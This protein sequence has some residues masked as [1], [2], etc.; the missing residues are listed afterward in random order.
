MDGGAWWAAVRGL[1]QSDTTERLSSSSSSSVFSG[2][3]V[4]A[5]YLVLPVFFAAKKTVLCPE[6]GTPPGG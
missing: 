3:H 5:T 6:A 1:A 2:R 4:D